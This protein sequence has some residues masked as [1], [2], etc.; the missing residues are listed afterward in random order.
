MDEETKRLHRRNQQISQ[1]SYLFNQVTY[2]PPRVA[3]LGRFHWIEG[4]ELCIHNPWG[5][6]NRAT[7]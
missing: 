6:I 7:S 1:L 2:Y 3:D 5:G 4:E